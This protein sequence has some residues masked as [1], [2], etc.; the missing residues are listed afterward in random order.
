MLFRN[1]KINYAESLV[2]FAYTLSFMLLI[3]TTTNLLGLI[4]DKII[5]STYYEI[6]VLFIYL[7]WT[8]INFFRKETKW[9]TTAKTLA[10]ILIVYLASYQI[11]NL[12]VNSLF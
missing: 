6:P 8:N 9:K 1:N 5:V 12:I 11:T 2:L 7:L 3:V 10:Q 4:P